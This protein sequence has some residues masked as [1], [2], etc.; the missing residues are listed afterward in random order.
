M[1]GRDVEW[2]T[3]RM[4]LP[5]LVN[6]SYSMINIKN[7][8]PIVFNVCRFEASDFNFENLFIEVKKIILRANIFHH[9]TNNILP[10]LTTLA[11]VMPTCFAYAEYVE[12]RNCTC[13]ILKTSTLLFFCLFYVVHVNFP[14]ANAVICLPGAKDIFILLSFG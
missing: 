1:P 7:G 4:A 11:F 9:H 3:W 8:V 12:N 13:S 10:S 6:T 14:I 2:N 5:F